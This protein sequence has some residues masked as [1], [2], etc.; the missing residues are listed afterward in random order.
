MLDPRNPPLVH[1]QC[2]APRLTERRVSNFRHRATE[3][4]LSPARHPTQFPA[5]SAASHAMQLSFDQH[6]DVNATPATPK[7]FIQDLES[8][9][10]LDSPTDPRAAPGAVPNGKNK[11]DPMVSKSRD[12]GTERD[13]S[14]ALEA[15]DDPLVF[16][17]RFAGG[18]KADLKRRAPWYLSDWL[19]AFSADS[20]GQALA[21]IAFLFFAC[22]SP[23]ITF[24]MLFDEQTEGHLGVVEMILSS[25]ISGIVYSIFSGQPLC[26]L[27]ATGP[28][29]AY[30]QVF[31]R[32]CVALELE[33][34]PARVWQGLW[35]AL[36]TVLLAVFDC[37]A[38][39]HHVTRFT[40]EIFSA[41]IS[42]IFIIEAFLSVGGLYASDDSTLGRARAFLGTL[43]CF[44]T[45]FIATWC[46]SLKGPGQVVLTKAIRTILGNYGVPVAIAV[47]MS[48]SYVFRGVGGAM[49]Q[50]P[51]EIVPTYVSNAT[52]KPRDWIVN[53]MGHD[54]AFPVWGIFFAAGPA[55]GLTLLGYLDQNLTSLLINRKAHNLRK[56]PGYHLDL[57]VCGAIVYP[58]CSFLG[59]P[60]THA[61]TV[62]SMTHLISLSTRE[63]VKLEGGGSTSKISRVI[64][65]RTTGLV[66]HVLLLLSLWLAGALVY[67]PR[68]CLFGVFLFMGVGSMA[69]NQVRR[70]LI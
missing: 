15:T 28:E 8:P 47:A 39:M 19:E 62:R 4:R 18:L 6:V 21:S 41:L 23:A 5:L 53:P 7:G 54:R 65:S 35:T 37:S 13:S 70:C 68:A 16:S 26:I 31:Y 55:L 66:I 48:V 50:V 43:L 2:A 44:G 69:D 10:V 12:A 51:S 17:R 1:T 60:F 30:T 67:V 46:K 32:L 29:L 34:L 25:A 40:E 52:G 58:I 20:R 9:I 64:E 36:F 24:G 63:V 61:A 42:L 14:A 56:P 45:F 49:L 3:S 57:F 38:L 22:L 59:L 27:G 11:I 33:F